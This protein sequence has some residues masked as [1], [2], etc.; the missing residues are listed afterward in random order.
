MKNMICKWCRHKPHNYCKEMVDII[1]LDSKWK[2]LHK[3]TGEIKKGFC[4]CAYYEPMTN[5]EYLEYKYEKE[6]T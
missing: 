5:L 1:Y 3:L 2:F 4:H 6:R